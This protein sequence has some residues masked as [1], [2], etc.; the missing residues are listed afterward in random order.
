MVI[1]VVRYIAAN[2]DFGVWY[3]DIYGNFYITVI[4]QTKGK[5]KT[6]SALQIILKQIDGFSAFIYTDHVLNVVLL[7]L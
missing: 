7:M 5:L 3:I 2:G 4:I 6:F 1:L